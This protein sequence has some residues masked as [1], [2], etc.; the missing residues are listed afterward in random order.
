M[1][2]TKTLPVK[3]YFGAGLTGFGLIPFRPDDSVG[4]GMAWSWLNVIPPKRP[5]ELM[6]QA[7]YQAHLYAGTFFQPAISYIPTPG[8]NSSFES[9]WAV[10]FRFTVLF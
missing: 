2:N 5:S 10:T 7:Y 3:D 4:A 6:F 1:N 8:V 9:A